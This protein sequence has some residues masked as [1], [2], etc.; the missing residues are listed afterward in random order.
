MKQT[1][2][3][4]AALAKFGAVQNEDTQ[5]GVDNARFFMIQQGFVV[6]PG[7]AARSTADWQVVL[8]TAN[9]PPASVGATDMD[10]GD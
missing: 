10:L 8:T 3:A 2:A 1:I 5:G 4:T 6:Q 7:W 9:D